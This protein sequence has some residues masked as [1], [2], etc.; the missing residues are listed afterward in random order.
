MNLIHRL[1]GVQC[2]LLEGPKPFLD[3]L[4]N[5]LWFDYETILFEEE[6]FW[7]QNSRCKWISLVT[8]IPNIFTFLL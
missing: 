7:A 6:S 5:K 1:H 3:D 8:K 4:Q 2:S